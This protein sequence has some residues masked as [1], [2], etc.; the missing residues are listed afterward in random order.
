MSQ[1]ARVFVVLNLILAAGF[2][3]VAASFLG[4]QADYKAK[5]EAEQKMHAA[6]K[7]TAEAQAANQKKEIERLQADLGATKEK[8]SNLETKNSSLTGE[9]ESLTTDKTN[10]DAQI[11]QLTKNIES[12][13]ETMKRMQDE[14]A[15]LTTSNTKLMQDIQAAQGNE[16]KA[17]EE[18]AKAK[19][20]ILTGENKLSDLQK[21]HTSLQDAKHEADLLIEIARKKGV[22]LTG[23]VAMEPI[24]D[25]RVIGVD[26]GLKL[27]QV[28]VGSNRKVSK[29]YVFDLVRGSS[30]I[31]RFN[32]D[33]VYDTT[34][35][36]TLTI[37]KPGET[38][39]VGDV[40]L[41]TLN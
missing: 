2:M 33:Q 5:L 4:Y 25:A 9:K 1:I 19:D 21:A 38:V 30:Y 26:M 23:L 34:A 6:D 24:A 37:L 31:G 36:G 10:K 20:S 11:A 17:N 16:R 22:D 28:N 39:T 27:I 8:A 32:V 18:L 3:C 41:N 14:R 15:A 35:A 12:V 29:G 13:N 40:A 7:A